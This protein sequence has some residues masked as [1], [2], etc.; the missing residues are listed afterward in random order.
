MRRPPPTKK[1]E[2]TLKSIMKTLPNK[3]QAAH[4]IA[5]LYVA[6]QFADDEVSFEHQCP[7][8]FITYLVSNLCP[9]YNTLSSLI[10]SLRANVA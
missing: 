7:D 1:K 4:Q 9:V 2:A 10:V 5:F 3:S 6:T 8:R